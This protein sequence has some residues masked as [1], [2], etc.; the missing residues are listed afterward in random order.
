VRARDG[1]LWFPTQNGVAFV[2]PARVP[3]ATEPP[4][5][6]IESLLADFTPIPLTSAAK[7]SPR[8][9]NFEIQY[10][11]LSFTS[12]ERI[13]FRYKLEGVD[14]EWVD[15]GARRTAY[16]SHVPQGKYRFQV[17]A[18]SRDGAWNPLGKS[19]EIELLPYIYETW[20]FCTLAALAAAGV[21]YAGWR[22]HTARLNEA[23][24]SQQAFT[25]QLI[26]RQESERERIAAELHDSIGQRLAIIKNLA[27]MFG[28]NQQHGATGPAQLQEISSESSQAIREIRDIA[29]NLRPYQLDQLGL[30]KAIEAMLRKASQ[31]S[32]IAFAPAL[33]PLEGRFPAESEISF[34]RIVQEAVNNILKHSSATQ[35]EITALAGDGKVNL[36]IH[37]NGKGF[38]RP[39]KTG[40]PF[41]EGFGLRGISERAEILGGEISIE[42]APGNGTTVSIEFDSRRRPKSPLP[43]NQGNPRSRQ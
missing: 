21:L 12:P 24:V 37:D 26:S 27:V 20:W 15:A 2:D 7:L 36:R 6:N 34:Y 19:I 16:Y 9:R 11:A 3:V 10:T 32:G 40:E 18:A 25:H 17:I 38:P 28:A 1:S 33:D 4:R 35:V 5:V 29:Y 39:F 31:A 8:Q 14:T 22:R 30:T 41:P 23:L 43:E 42:S 13:R